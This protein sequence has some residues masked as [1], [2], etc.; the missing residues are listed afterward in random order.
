MKT[1]V[2]SGCD[3]IVIAIDDSQPANWAVQVGR[4][5]AGR[6]SAQVMLVHVVEP[7]SAVIDDLAAGEQAEAIERAQGT[8][9]LQRTSSLFPSGVKVDISLRTGF[10]SDQIVAVARDWKADMLVIG[11][12]GRGRISQCFLG[13]IADTV[14]R[15]SPCPVITVAHE[16]RHVSMKIADAVG[17]FPDGAAPAVPVAPR[18]GARDCD[19]ADG[20]STDPEHIAKLS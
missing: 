3:R 18:P 10:P 20:E 14:I 13:S 15:Q 8:D 9:L 6:L 16:P 17:P 11:T 4:R 7:A 5:L 2:A 19:W 12:R 1:T